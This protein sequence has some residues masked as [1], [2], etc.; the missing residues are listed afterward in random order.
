[1]TAMPRHGRY[2]CCSDPFQRLAELALASRSCQVTLPQG[3]ADPP[4]LQASE[5]QSKEPQ[6]PIARV[7]LLHLPV[8]P[9]AMYCPAQ[10]GHGDGDG[11]HGVP[12]QRIAGGKPF[13]IDE[14]WFGELLADIGQAKGAKVETAH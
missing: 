13:N 7:Q 5:G 2:R 6:L 10:C 8:E 1:M 12:K 4:D 9:S 14:P 3:A 11:H